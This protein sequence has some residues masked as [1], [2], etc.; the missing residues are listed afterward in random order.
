[1]FASRQT[2]LGGQGQIRVRSTRY[3]QFFSTPTS[4][5]RSV[6]AGP[7]PPWF[8]PADPA[9]LAGH[10]HG[11]DIRGTLECFASASLRLISRAAVCGQTTAK[12][13]R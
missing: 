2:S 7:L 6:R 10:C 4:T 11:S 13:D 1:M 8:T 9:L 3:Q 12:G 5:N